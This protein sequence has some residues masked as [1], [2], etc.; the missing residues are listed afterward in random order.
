M[1]TA[2]TAY[3]PT[4]ATP[5]HTP[6]LPDPGNVFREAPPRLPPHQHQGSHP[7]IPAPHF[8]QGNP[9][10][11]GG[12][13]SSDGSWSLSHLPLLELVV[14]DGGSEPR[15]SPLHGCLLQMPFRWRV[16]GPGTAPVPEPRH[17]G[18]SSR[19]QDSPCPPYTPSSGPGP[20]E[21]LK[22]TGCHP[23]RH[24]TSPPLEDARE[25]GPAEVPAAGGLRGPSSTEMSWLRL[26]TFRCGC[27]VALLVA[28]ALNRDVLSP[29]R[30]PLA[31]RSRRSL[32]GP[33][34][35]STDPQAG[36]GTLGAGGG[37]RGGGCSGQA[38]WSPPSPD[39]PPPPPWG[40]SPRG[41]RRRGSL[42]PWAGP[43]FLRSWAPPATVSSVRGHPDLV[44]SLAAAPPHLVYED[45]QRV[46]PSWGES[47][48]RPGHRFRTRLLADARGRTL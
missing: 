41:I 16:P 1:P 31:G 14:A 17:S 22:R 15:L 24:P 10:V 40:A 36:S 39:E 27:V 45:H 3:S 18:H 7:T 13:P 37:E 32:P 23:F 38:D 28:G 29:S 47:C 48:P 26:V 30:C 19:K 25:R 42:H 4:K 20:Y 21:L 6:S 2:A 35:H 11:Q 33:P 46:Q 43:P 12:F 5:A 8:T 44:G 9:P 34:A